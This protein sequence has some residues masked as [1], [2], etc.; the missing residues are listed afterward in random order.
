MTERE[1]I[2]SGA[3]KLAD[4]ALSSAGLGSILLL[5]YV[6]YY[7]GWT[8]QRQFSNFTGFA[9]YYG[10][11]ASLAVLLFSCLLLKKDYKINVAL[12]CLSLAGSFYAAELILEI[13]SPA[14]SAP[15]PIW[16][17]DGESKQEKQQKA[18]KIE[19]E[20]G[21]RF[22]TRER[23]EVIADLKKQG[24]DS[25]PAIIPRILLSIPKNSTKRHARS[26]IT[27]RGEEIL[28]LAGVSN[29]TTVVCNETGRWMAYKSDEHGFNNPEG[30]WRSG[31]IDIASVGDSFTQGYCLPRQESFMG[32]VRREY[33]ATLNL[34]MAADGPLYM[35]AVINEYLSTLKPRIVLWGYFEEDA[36][37]DLEIEKK[38]PLLM[39]YLSDGFN[40]GLAQRQNDIDQALRS[41]IEKARRDKE[42]RAE[43]PKTSK[44][45]A[46]L[47]TFAKMGTLRKS[48]GMSFGE[49]REAEVSLESMQGSDLDLFREIL[50][51]AKDRVHGW[52]GKLYF[53]YLPSWKRYADLSDIGVQ[54]RGRVL[55][56]VKNLDI[57]I[58][59]IHSAFAAR[60]VP[61]ALFPF[62]G[63]G[64]Y[65]AAGHELVGKEILRALSPLSPQ[66][67][68]S[69]PMGE[70]SANP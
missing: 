70:G 1:K 62:H 4:I 18:A 20:F 11:P 32:I 28:P 38:S 14:L 47:L 7:Y 66:S 19:R 26:V 50:L 34:G 35:L 2:L 16:V 42:K 25:V 36:L 5:F 61:L 24:V 13:L 45:M 39:R 49:A 15:R 58:I 56:L 17:F 29:I 33:P 57:P 37:R 68:A 6:L 31:Q 59:D 12:F 63:A 48:L 55:N 69:T 53:I 9:L 30:V 65:L 40:Q 46:K 44:W 67:P 21:V 51:Q 8:G 41:Y 60:D 52:G 22:D 27:I 43:T 3:T 54:Q 23:I 64:H 10:L